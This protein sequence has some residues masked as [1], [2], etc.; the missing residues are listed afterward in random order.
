M[1]LITQRGYDVSQFDS[2]D[3]VH[4][5]EHLDFLESDLVHPTHADGFADKGDPISV[6][7]SITGVVVGR[8]ATAA[9]DRVV[10]DVKKGRV[11]VLSVVASNGSGTTSGSAG[12]KI[13]ISASGVLS[14]IATGDVFGVLLTS[15][16]GSASAA[17]AAVAINVKD[18]AEFEAVS[19]FS[20]T[21]TAAAPAAETTGTSLL[22][23][24]SNAVAATLADGANVGQVKV[25]RATDVSAL[26]TVTVATHEI[27][28]SEIF[29]FSTVGDSLVLQWDGLQWVT[30]AGNAQHIELLAADGVALIHGFSSLNGT[31]SCDVT[32]ANGLNI[33]DRKTFRVITSIANPPTVTI[34]THE[35]EA[36][37]VYTLS[38]IGDSLELV[39]EGLQWI[40]VG[41]NA[42]ITEAL[43]TDTA[44][45]IFGLSTLN[46]TASCDVT[47]AVGTYQGQRKTFR[48]ITSIA[49][50]PTVTVTGHVMDVDAPIVY[51][52]NVIGDTAILEW[53][54]LQWVDVGGNVLPVE[55]A[56]TATT[57]ISTIGATD[58][59]SN[60][61][62]VSATLAD[63]SYIGQQKI[64][65]MS[66]DASTAS[67]LTIASHETADGEVLNFNALDEYALLIWTGTEWADVEKTATV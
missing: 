16:T 7:N 43:A 19:S 10:V 39:W 21:L 61:G 58:L 25:F 14:F 50:P 23:A 44:A 31:A 17:K 36:G 6:N 37:L 53:D 34:A 41:G 27:A 24:N 18:I 62:A 48:A 60:G 54:G 15:L 67:T 63:G 28:V 55:L 56:V 66:I 52:F 35:L 13:F 1:S 32:L 33:G 45:A 65:T 51:T 26:V 5:G 59:N 2:G 11:Y 47:L 8:S 4:E 12:D 22:D 46:G 3:F 20:E 49:N 38:I 64:V 42:Q 9:T 29:T 30:E 40:T 57:A